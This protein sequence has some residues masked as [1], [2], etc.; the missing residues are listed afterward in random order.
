MATSAL[1]LHHER[2][3]QATAEADCQNREIVIDRANLAGIGR[4][5]D[6]T[7]MHFVTQEKPSV[8]LLALSVS[9]ATTLAALT[10]SGA[11]T[12]SGGAT[13]GAATDSAST[14]QIGGSESRKVSA[15]T[16]NLTLDATYNT[17]EC[18]ATA[19]SFV[20]TLPAAATCSGRRY[21][22]HKNDTS[23]NTVT[24]DGNASET[25][26]GALT[27]ILSGNAGNSH[28][29][30]VSNGTNW[31]IEYL[32]DE[33][34]FTATLTGCTTSPT[35]T[36]YYTRN[37]KLVFALLPA[38]TAT[39]NTN[40]ATLTGWP[41]AL[42]PAHAIFEYMVTVDA[43]ANRSGAASLSGTTLTLYQSAI[44]SASS[45]GFSAAGTK[46]IPNDGTPFT[47]TLQ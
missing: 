5:N 19:G 8:A 25:I 30:I 7:L 14:Q 47:Y 40:A 22:F 21:A 24:I 33:G 44:N 45:T 15:I 26:D 39:S 13:V 41:A 3:A 34:S 11:S 23:A 9:G 43:A 16:G 10:A 18:N 28:L 2:S 6:G 37:G 42:T 1:Y 32:Y 36:V 31:R 29:V 35:G 38:I 20:I 12:L 4:A 27:V 17:M 46:G